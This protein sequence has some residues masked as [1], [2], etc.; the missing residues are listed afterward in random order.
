MSKK[1]DDWFV[2]RGGQRF[3]PVTFTQLMEA[4][5]QGRLEP[6]TDLIFGGALAEWTPAGDVDGV[7]ERKERRKEEPA[8]RGHRA[9]DNSLAD[10]G[11]Y[12]SDSQ[13]K[14]KLHLP[15]ATR[16]GYFLGVTVLPTILA[17]G[18]ARFIPEIADM[19][20]EKFA[21]YTPLLV[22]IIPLLV[23][24]ITVK[25]F[26]NLAM[27]G[28]WTFGLLVPLMNWWLQYRL[29]C[30]PTGY[31]YTKKMD[32]IGWILAVLYWLILVGG[33]AAYFVI[34][35]VMINDLIESGQLQQ[36]RNQFDELKAAIPTPAA[37]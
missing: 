36:F 27:S 12:D 1:Q 14:T 3:G 23:L 33:I 21:Q 28:W 13:P 9:P 7:F 34:G 22:L 20:G 19:V 25:R 17:I 2:S 35:A 5:K 30:C 4:A 26:Q 29:I 16:L 15:G 10:S 11:S 6:R 24:V 18:F 31:G 8:R 37:E 32:P